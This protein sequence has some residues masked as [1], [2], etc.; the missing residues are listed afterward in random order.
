MHVVNYYVLTTTILT[1]QYPTTY[2][3][4]RIEN[5]TT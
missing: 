5:Q 1:A 2:V 4:I 3:Y